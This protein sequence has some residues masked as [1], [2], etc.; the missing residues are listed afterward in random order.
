MLAPNLQLFFS[1]ISIT[2]FSAIIIK[3]RCPSV[4]SWRYWNYGRVFLYFTFF[5]LLS[6]FLR[7]GFAFFF[8]D[9]APCV[10]HLRHI[11]I[12]HFFVCVCCANNGIRTVRFVECI[13]KNKFK[14]KSGDPFYAYKLSIALVF[15]K[16]QT[17]IL[18]S[19]LYWECAVLEFI[20]L[21]SRRWALSWLFL[22]ILAC[23]SE[24]RDEMNNHKKEYSA[25]NTNFRQWTCKGKIYV[26]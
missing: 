10:L 2:E 22:N 23:R 3:S 15:L 8:E 12:I 9:E 21:A 17:L 7:P 19:S 14:K 20:K 18:W 1:K 25:S 26:P 5:G 6:S 16:I 11:T 24:L 13:K 4:F